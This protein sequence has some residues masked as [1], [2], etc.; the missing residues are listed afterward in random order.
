MG[1]L[2]DRKVRTLINV[3]EHK[4]NY[5][6]PI[7][8]M[9]QTWA[10]AYAHKTTA[11]CMESLD[12]EI[13]IYGKSVKDMYFDAIFIFGMNR[14]IKVYKAL[15]YAPYFISND[16]VTLQCDAET[17]IVKDDELDRFIKDPS[18]F[19]REVAVARRYPEIM[20]DSP[21]DINALKAAF[22]E[23]MAFGGAGAKKDKA[24]KKYYDTPAATG[25]LPTSPP[26]DQYICYRGLTAG[27]GDMRR[28]PQAVLD[29]C[30]A[31]LPLFMP[32]EKKYGD[33]PWIMNPIVGANYLNP[34]QFEKF[35]A[36][37]YKKLCDAYIE[38]G[39]K[40]FVAMEGRWGKE[41][42]SFYN[43]FP[44]NSFVNFIEDDDPFE[45]QKLIGGKV[46]ISYPFPINIL[47][48]G[49][50]DQ[51]REEARRVT[52]KIGTTGVFM[53]ANRC[54]LSPNDIKAENYA[55]LSE[56]CRDY[57]VK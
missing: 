28:R 17:A 20:K 22:K 56:F 8:S 48:N 55:A 41:K 31:M 14:P 50:P 35:M 27:L 52:D 4:D 53:A 42:Y 40:I 9:A 44:E 43:D 24:L 2:Y 18:A 26:L 7:M 23:F 1:E 32:T 16:G 33:F 6:M 57:T 11:E 45:V 12:K 51:V 21:A 19:F 47:K 37:T 3:A 29:A 36:P 34:Q 5:R 39:A 25:G 49:T 13:E 46:A 15:G 54:F 38:R 10:I 30:E